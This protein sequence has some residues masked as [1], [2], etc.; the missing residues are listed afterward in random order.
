VKDGQKE[1]KYRRKQTRKRENERND[2]KEWKQNLRHQTIFDIL[3]LCV[4]QTARGQAFVICV[5][6]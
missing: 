4:N 1:I 6:R 3:V 5:I 2:L